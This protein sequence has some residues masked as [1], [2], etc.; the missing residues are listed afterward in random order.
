MSCRVK[1]IT[2]DPHKNTV[3]AGTQGGSLYVFKISAGSLVLVKTIDNAH[4]HGPV[5]ELWSNEAKLLSGGKDGLVN[6]WRFSVKLGSIDLQ[7]LKS[8]DIAEHTG[9]GEQVAIK[10]ITFQEN[11]PALAVGTSTNQVVQFNEVSN[12]TSCVVAGHSGGHSAKS[13]NLSLCLILRTRTSCSVEEQMEIFSCG[14]SGP[15]RW[16]TV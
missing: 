7:Y 8:Y 3:I 10:S 11:P 13:L 1:P 4:Q 2:S 16:W 6:M 12:Q 9:R 14:T 15:R 5:Y